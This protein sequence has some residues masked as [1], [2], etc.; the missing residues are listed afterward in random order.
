MVE[1]LSDSGH[2]GLGTDSTVTPYLFPSLSGTPGPEI[3]SELTALVPL[4]YTPQHI[5]A[6]HLP[7]SAWTGQPR[8][9]QG[10]T[11][12]AQGTDNTALSSSPAESRLS[13]FLP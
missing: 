8:T 7:A 12:P 10:S 5:P 3:C 1:G 2:T 13:C 11:C 4:R 6:F 9:R